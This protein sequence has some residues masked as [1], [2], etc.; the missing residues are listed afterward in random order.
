MIDSL[1]A[2]KLTAGTI[3]AGKINVVN[4]NASNISAGIITGANLAINLNSGEVTFQKGVI[5]RADKRFS[6]D[7]TKG[8]IDSYGSEG[9]FTISDVE[10]LLSHKFS[11]KE[12]FGTITY[13]SLSGGFWTGNKGLSLLGEAG[14]F[15][16]TSNAD[17]GYILGARN[18]GSGFSASKEGRINLFSRE[19]IDISAGNLYNSSDISKIIPRIII[20]ND[21]SRGNSIIDVRADKIYLSGATGIVRRHFELI[22]DST[23]N[24]VKSDVIFRRTYASAANMYITPNG[25]IGRSTSASKYKLAIEEDKTDNYKNILKLKHKTW[26]DKANTEA[27]ARALDN[28]DTFDWDNPEDEVLPVERI[29]GLIAED[30]VEAGLTEFVSYGELNDDGTKEVEGIQYDRLV[31]PLLQIVKDHQIEIE[32]LK[33]RIK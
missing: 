26:Y 33:E 23:G 27:Y 11:N 3:D 6:I 17:K 32:K 7:V 19:S 18:T 20:G 24:L 4:L 22:A 21:T 25:A 31:V 13:K 14:A 15:I 2:N 10:I 8:V 12:K 16:G 9:G 28:K 30:L 29:H 5:Q 1:S